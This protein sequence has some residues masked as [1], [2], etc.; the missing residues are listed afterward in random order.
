MKKVSLENVVAIPFCQ[1]R[2]HSKM[3]WNKMQNV[4]HLQEHVFCWR[5]KNNLCQ[6]FS[7]P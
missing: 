5:F 2:S 6:E 1:L 4:H 3:S 7:K